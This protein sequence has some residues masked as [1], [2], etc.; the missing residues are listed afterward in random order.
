MV[1]RGSH[2]YPAGRHKPGYCPKVTERLPKR[3]ILASGGLK[4]ITKNYIEV[5]KPRESSLLTFIGL[6]TAIIAGEG[7]PPLDRLL[8]A[9]VT[10]LLASAGANGLTNYLDRNVDAQ[11]QRTRNRALPSKRIPR[12]C[13]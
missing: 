2:F 7:Y 4:I 10:I 8:L 5:L 13:F 11:M 9:G 3:P 6:C 12:F 1:T